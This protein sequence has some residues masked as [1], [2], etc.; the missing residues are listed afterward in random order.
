MWL[1]IQ[2]GHVLYRTQPSASCRVVSI[3][4]EIFAEGKRRKIIAGKIHNTLNL[5]K[6]NHVPGLH[7]QY[8]MY[9]QL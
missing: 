8:L 1:D 2:E 3:S 5:L 4:N 9:L 6:L 7:M